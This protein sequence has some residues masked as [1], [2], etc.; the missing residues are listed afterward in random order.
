VFDEKQHDLD[1]VF[2]AL[3]ELREAYSK[4]RRRIS[5]ECCVR[6]RVFLGVIEARDVQELVDPVLRR[7]GNLMLEDRKDRRRA[8]SR[9]AIL[10]K[11]VRLEH[12]RR[13]LR[14]A[15]EGLAQTG[16]ADWRIDSTLDCARLVD[17]AHRDL[18]NSFVDASSMSLL[19]RHRNRQEVERAD[20]AALAVGVL[21][22]DILDATELPNSYGIG[23]H[24]IGA[25]RRT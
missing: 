18:H 2:E 16:S 25:V 22:A 6:L 12:D 3:N 19:K 15:I 10:A 23:A 14:K 13:V 17:S 24:I 21:L 20:A 11:E 1:K 9:E 7:R 8:L 4:I 5:D